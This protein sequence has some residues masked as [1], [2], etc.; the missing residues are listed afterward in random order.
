MINDYEHLDLARYMRID[1][2]LHTPQE[3]IDKQVQIISI[4]SDIPVDDILHLPIAEY[5]ALAR[6]TAFLGVLCDPDPV[7][8]EGVA[9]GGFFL[10]P[11]KDFT[12]INTAQYVDF[13][14]LAKDLPSTIPQLL[15][16]FLVP[17]GH[18]YNEGYDLKAVQ[19]AVGKLMLPH[20]LGLTAFFF[21]QFKISI[22]NTLTSLK[23]KARTAKEKKK[24]EDLRIQA[25]AMLSL[26]TGD[27]SPA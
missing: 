4:L 17:E 22:M 24:M 3:D 27:G 14:L 13:Q 18:A 11:T 21:E 20:A 10:L 19:E 2:V 1:R 6:Q 16:V 23:M 26:I 25:E 5:G 15:S 12:K 9:I 8:E 7:G